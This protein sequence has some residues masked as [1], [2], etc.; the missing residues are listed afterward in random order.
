MQNVKRLAVDS[1]PILD[2][3]RRVWSKITFGFLSVMLDQLFSKN[4][5]SYGPWDHSDTKKRLGDESS[6]LDPRAAKCDLTG[7]F[8]SNL[9]FR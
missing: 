8:E 6:S 2:H 4:S 9:T 3:F 1:G 5:I 7:V